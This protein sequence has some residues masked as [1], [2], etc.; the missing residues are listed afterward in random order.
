M[1]SGPSREEDQRTLG[2]GLQKIRETWLG[3]RP[4][5]WPKRL[6]ATENVGRTMCRPY[7]P[8]GAARYDDDDVV[9][10]KPY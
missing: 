9:Q 4:G 3:G 8:T 1:L 5:M 7:A 10:A 6:V 2:E